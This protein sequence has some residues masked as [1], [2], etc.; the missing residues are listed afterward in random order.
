MIDVFLIILPIILLIVMMIAVGISVGIINF[1]AWI[2][3]IMVGMIVIMVLATGLLVITGVKDSFNNSTTENV[4]KLNITSVPSFYDCISKYEQQMYPTDTAKQLCRQELGYVPK[5][6]ITNIDCNA[7]IEGAIKEENDKMM[8]CDGFKWTQISYEY[9]SRSK[10]IFWAQHEEPNYKYENW[11]E[12]VRIYVDGY[13]RG[14]PEEMDNPETFESRVSEEELN[15]P[16]TKT[17][18]DSMGG[19]FIIITIVIIGQFMISTIRR[20]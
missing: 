2:P 8:Y 20:F 17:L 12:N 13:D 11:T 10:P 9:F 7:S 16:F 14:Y 6:D 18:I 4:T 19:I 1:D 15:P 3:I 5:D